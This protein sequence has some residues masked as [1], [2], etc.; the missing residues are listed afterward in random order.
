MVNLVKIILCLL[1]TLLLGCNQNQTANH[2]AKNDSIEKY[3]NLAS[4]DT[5]TYNQRNQYN[6]KA[7]SLIDL[8]K[9][10]TVVRF[11]LSEVSYYYLS[12]RNWKQ[13]KKSSNLLL[14]FLNK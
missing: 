12:L 13:F 7:F 8:S 10:D 11:Y 1:L 5:F 3:L 4:N 14:L 6:Q 2:N 9:N